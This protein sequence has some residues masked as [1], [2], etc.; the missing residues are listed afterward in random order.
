MSRILTPDLADFTPGWWWL[1]VSPPGAALTWLHG[2]LFR[3]DIGPYFMTIDAN[4]YERTY[5]LAET[6]EAITIDLDGIL[7]PIHAAV[8]VLH[9]D[10]EVLLRRQIANATRTVEAHGTILGLLITADIDAMG[11]DGEQ[12]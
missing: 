11:F 8:P 9:P 4:G 2:R 5:G 3:P 12:P 1:Q 10:E 7:A 6:S